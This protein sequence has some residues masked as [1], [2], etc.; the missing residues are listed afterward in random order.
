MSFYLFWG[1]GK[2]Y[3]KHPQ[4]LRD[5]HQQKHYPGDQKDLTLKIV[6]DSEIP[7]EF[8]NW[9]QPQVTLILGNHLSYQEVK[10]GLKDFADLGG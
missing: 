4:T 9:Q 10:D 8:D 2:P 6:V 7:L 3:T 1:S 5:V